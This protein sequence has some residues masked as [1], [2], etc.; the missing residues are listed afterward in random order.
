[1]TD[2]GVIIVILDQ[3]KTKISTMNFKC[4]YCLLYLTTKN[5][6]KNHIKY[7]MGA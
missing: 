3:H 4:E 7:G 1:M 2:L 5:L 6:L